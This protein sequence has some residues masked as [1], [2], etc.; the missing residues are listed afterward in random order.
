M[1]KTVVEVKNLTKKFTSGKKIIKAVDN[2]SFSIKEGEIVGLLGPNGAGK[3]TT[4]QMLLGLIT[5]TKGEIDIFGKKLKNHREEILQVMNFSSTYTHLPW[6][7]SVWENLIV[8]A[9]LYSVENPEEKV[10]EVIKIM[11]LAEVKNKTIIELS[12]GWITRVNLARTF[13]NS[14]KLIL[15]DEPT[16]SL[17]PEGAYDIRNEII[18]Y[19]KEKQATI[20]WT[21]HNMAE[22]EEVCDR[23]IFLHKGKV[24][25]EDTPEGLAGTIKICRISLMVKEGQKKLEKICSENNWQYRISGR[26]STIETTEQEIPILLSKLIENNIDYSEISID[27]P[28]LEDYFIQKAK[29]RKT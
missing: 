28:N 14:P 3:T 7:L 1:N 16:A 5:P 9:L 6:R 10:N 19:R 21:S 17:D 26:F 23:V 29:E 13:L 11:K 24:V 15:L 27:K 12:S 22:V 8:V 25:A 4:I 18:N 2:I 20:L